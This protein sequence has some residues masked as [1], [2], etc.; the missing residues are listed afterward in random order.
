MLLHI[1]PILFISGLYSTE[2]TFLL[3][4]QLDIFVSLLL[5]FL[6]GFK[7]SRKQLPCSENLTLRISQLEIYFGI[8]FIHTLQHYAVTINDWSQRLVTDN[9]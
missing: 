4:R 9:G 5:G 7:D 8:K 2:K 1:S 3:L 6:S